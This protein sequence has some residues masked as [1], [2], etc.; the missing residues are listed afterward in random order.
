MLS[1]DFKPFHAFARVSVTFHHIS[2]RKA[3]NCTKLAREVS[4]VSGG[5]VRG[6]THETPLS[7]L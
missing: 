2:H 7:L 5:F 4:Y 1:V 3:E 6:F